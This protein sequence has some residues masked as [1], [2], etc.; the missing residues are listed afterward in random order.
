M[1][2]DLTEVAKDFETYYLDGG[3]GEEDLYNLLYRPTVTDRL[4]PTMKIF[5]GDK[6]RGADVKLSSILQPFQKGW[7]P[8]GDMTLSPIEIDK[9]PLKIDVE[10]YPD[11]IR[12]SWAGFWQDLSKQERKNWPLIRY[13]VE[14]H[15]LPKRDEEYELDVVFGGRFF[16]P[17]PDV[18]GE[19][20]GSMDGIRYLRN[21]AIESGRCSPIILGAVP[22]DAKDFCDYLEEFAQGINK[23]YWNL[24]MQLGMS[25]DLQRRYWEGYGLKYG[26]RNDFQGEMPTVKRTNLRVVSVPSMVDSEIIWTAPD[27]H[28][29]RLRDPQEASGRPK[30]EEQKRAVQMLSDWRKGNGFLFGETLFTNDVDLGNPVVRTIGPVA[31]GGSAEVPVSGTDFKGLTAATFD[32]NDVFASVT[33]NNDRNI[34]F[35]APPAG[36]GTR[37]L[38]LT[39]EFGTT[40]YPVNVA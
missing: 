1:R 14:K 4:F 30:L 35:D 6:Y 27:E 34:T 11:D 18:A 3:Q 17:T 29:V 2:I 22:T 28:K 36:A 39:N 10:V 12:S 37:N 7:T 5:R 9:F 25:E 24:R 26:L 16:A 38:V 19:A 15:I 31:N 20:Y 13:M 32:G 21:K 23:R 40:T 33:I 8:K